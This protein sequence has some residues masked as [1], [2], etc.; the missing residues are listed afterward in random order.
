MKNLFLTLLAVLIVWSCSKYT[1]TELTEDQKSSIITEILPQ[2]EIS[3]QGNME[4]N[5][6]QAFSILCQQEEDG[7]KLFH[8]RNSWE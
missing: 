5:T 8:M 7:W 2:N 3:G 6:E 4:R 1:K